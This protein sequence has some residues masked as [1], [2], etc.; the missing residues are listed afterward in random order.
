MRGAQAGSH[1]GKEMDGM[2]Q[3]GA[4]RAEENREAGQRIQRGYRD[5]KEVLRKTETGRWMDGWSG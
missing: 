1:R 5:C 3:Y 4:H 2:W